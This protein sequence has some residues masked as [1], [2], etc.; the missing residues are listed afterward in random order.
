MTWLIYGVSVL[1]VTFYFLLDGDSM[2]DWIINRCPQK[3][4]ESLQVMAHE[5]D[6]N[7]QAFFRGQVILGIGAGLIMLFIFM[8]LGVHYALLLSVFLAIWEILC[9]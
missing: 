2:K 7:L 8:G 5:M 6:K 3:H 9:L 1:V 4:R